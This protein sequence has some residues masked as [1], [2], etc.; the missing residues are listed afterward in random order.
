MTF[1]LAMLPNYIR[2]L[3]MRSWIRYLNCT[4]S[5]KVCPSAPKWYLHF[6]DKSQPGGSGSS[7]GFSNSGVTSFFSNRLAKLCHGH[8]WKWE[9]PWFPLGISGLIEPS[10]LIECSVRCLG[11]QNLLLI[12]SSIW[13]CISRNDTPWS[14][15]RFVDHVNI[16]F[17]SFAAGCLFTY[18]SIIEF[19]ASRSTI[20]LLLIPSSIR[21]GLRSEWLR[22]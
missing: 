14:F 9:F 13:G 6:L 10:P 21:S 1:G 22:H 4:H 8:G 2:W 5:S 3:L 12:K 19:K 16:N 18:Y 7:L 15:R 11:W 20:F 17:L